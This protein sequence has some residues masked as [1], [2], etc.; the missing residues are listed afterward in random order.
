MLQPE[1][2][3]APVQ[4][5]NNSGELQWGMMT[6]QGRMV[7][8]DRG[9]GS[10]LPSTSSPPPRRPDRCA[11]SSRLRS[12]GMRLPHQSAHPRQRMLIFK[13]KR[14]DVVALSPIEMV[15]SS[16]PAA[17]CHRPHHRRYYSAPINNR[18]AAPSCSGA[19]HLISRDKLQR[20]HNSNCRPGNFRVP[21]RESRLRRR[22]HPRSP[23]SASR[24]GR[25]QERSHHYSRSI[26]FSVLPSISRVSNVTPSSWDMLRLAQAV[27]RA[28]CTP[29][30]KV[31]RPPASGRRS[32]TVT[33]KP[34]LPQLRSTGQAGRARADAGDSSRTLGPRAQRN[35]SAG[36]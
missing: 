15:T 20:V 25:R 16:A 2:P 26:W 24:P 28:R 35:R 7:N 34:L 31:F 21:P 23:A 8:S 22:T 12:V 17:G 27:G 1:R 10:S 32:I 29:P 4:Q 14:R 18:R 19:R 36:G 11:F 9:T 3:H 30:R 13:V 5:L 33:W 6:S